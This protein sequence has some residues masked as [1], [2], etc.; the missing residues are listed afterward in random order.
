MQAMSPKQLRQANIA[1]FE[2]LLVDETGSE[3]R[4]LIQRILAEER[5]KPDSAYPVE[6][7][8]TKADRPS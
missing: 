6:R 8:A 5:A 4:A 2:R 1:R 3:R 7:P